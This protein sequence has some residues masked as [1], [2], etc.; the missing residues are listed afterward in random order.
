MK[1]LDQI[2]ERCRIKNYSPNTART[3]R[4]WAEEFLRWIRREHGEW[5]HPLQLGTSDVEAF[6]SHLA[7]R[8]RVAASTQNQALSSLLWISPADD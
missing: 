1:L 4:K 6:L 8:R 5:V 7:T 2:T 3:Y